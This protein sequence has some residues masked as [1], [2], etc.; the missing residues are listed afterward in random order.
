ME[1]VLT[2]G[3][4][5]AL[6]DAAMNFRES[7]VILDHITTISTIDPFI[8]SEDTEIELINSVLSG[9]TGSI[10]LFGGVAV[11]NYCNIERGRNI[12]N[13]DDVEWGE[14]RPATVRRV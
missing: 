4:N 3:N 7:T 6:F 8:Y 1:R 5:T 14:Y 9:N 13:G 11:V 2:F 12:I 10:S